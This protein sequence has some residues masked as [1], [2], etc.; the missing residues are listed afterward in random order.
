[1]ISWPGVLI[2]SSGSEGNQELG[3][4]FLTCNF[5]IKLVS[6]KIIFFIY[7]FILFYLCW[8]ENV[9]VSNDS[10]F[11]CIYIPDIVA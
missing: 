7:K 10:F 9:F 8:V 2:F 5:G 6:K 1:M 11:K 4:F 3:L